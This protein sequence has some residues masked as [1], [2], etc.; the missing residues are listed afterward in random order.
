VAAEWLE[1]LGLPVPEALTADHGEI[2]HVNGAIA[3]A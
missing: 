3:V 2:A 1:L